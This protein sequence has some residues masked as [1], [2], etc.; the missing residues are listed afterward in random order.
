MDISCSLIRY[1]VEYY[2]DRN[3]SSVRLRNDDRGMLEM[4]TSKM[5]TSLN[6]GKVIR[7]TSVVHQGKGYSI[8]IL[9]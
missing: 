9:H 5:G 1:C 7:V 3:G 2:G 4:R 6:K 8:N